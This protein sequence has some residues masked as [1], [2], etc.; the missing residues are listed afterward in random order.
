MSFYLP[1]AAMLA[2]TGLAA[3]GIATSAPSPPPLELPL[4][5]ELSES[6]IID[7]ERDR[8]RRLTV[9][10]MI[11]DKGP[12]R[13]M[14]DTGAQATLLSRE[15]A[16]QLELFDRQ[17]ASLMG[18]AS[19]VPVET[20]EIPDFRLGSRS[21]LI[22]SAALVDAENIG[23]VD[24]VLGVDSLQNQRVLLDFDNSRIA[25]ANAKQLGG[26]RGFEIVVRG[27]QRL[28]QLIL[29]RAQLDG[30]R[31][32]VIVDTGAQG[33]IGNKALLERLRR[34]SLI[35]ESYLTDINGVQKTGVVKMTKQLSFGRARVRNVPILFVDSPVFAVL[36]LQDRPAIV[37]GMEELMLF[38]RVAIDFQTQRVLFDL[39]ASASLP[40]ISRIRRG[41]SF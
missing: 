15:L 12:F 9:P 26:N 24:G 30:V 39:P 13:F 29:T 2:A 22:Q 4:P 23:D 33:T 40:D 16:D 6:E 3:T 19:E 14:I 36:G 27:R 1:F 34:A 32:H 31:I 37:L 28:G 10:V 35:G 38:K 25:V 5:P 8:Y 11:G 17:P 7:L 41:R 18:M 21:F 20:V